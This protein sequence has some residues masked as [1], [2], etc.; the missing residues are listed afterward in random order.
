M[1]DFIVGQKDPMVVCDAETAEVVLMNKQAEACFGDTSEKVLEVT[2]SSSPSNSVIIDDEDPKKEQ[3]G[4][5][6]LKD[7]VLKAETAI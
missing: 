1:S 5:I 3:F 4:R 2:A 7:F 6:A